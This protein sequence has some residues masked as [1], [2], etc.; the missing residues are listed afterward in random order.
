M[1]PRA[2]FSRSVL[3]SLHSP[4]YRVFKF[5]SPFPPHLPPHDFFSR[6]TGVPRTHL[7]FMVDETR[8]AVSL[9]LPLNLIQTSLQKAA[10][11]ADENSPTTRFADDAESLYSFDSVSTNGRLLDRL[12]LNIDTYDDNDVD[13]FARRRNLAILV[14]STGRLL[15]RLGLDDATIMASSPESST[16]GT[17]ATSVASPA[18]AAVSALLSAASVERYRPVRASSQISVE[19][20]R[21]L[22]RNPSQSRIALKQAPA[23]VV[24]QRSNT[25]V[26]SMAADFAV[27][28]SGSTASLQEPTAAV[29]GASMPHTPMRLGSSK[30]V[31]Q[32]SP[33]AED[34]ELLPRF[35]RSVSLGLATSV[36]S[37]DSGVSAKSEAL[38]E[39]AIR[40]ALLLRSQGKLREALYQLQ[41]LANA[42][43]NSPKAMLLYAMALRVGLGVKLNELQAVKWLSRCVLVLQAAELEHI[44][45]L[46]IGAMVAKMAALGPDELVA[47]V[48]RSRDFLESTDPVKIAAFYAS[49]PPGQVEKLVLTS[50]KDSTTQAAAFQQLG[51]CVLAGCGT[52]QK[53]EANGRFLLLAA[54]ALGS[55]DAMAKL[56][57]LWQLKTK[58]FKKDLYVAAAWL[59]LAETFGRKDIGNSWIYKDKYME[60]KK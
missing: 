9:R 4:R 54:A 18:S 10:S 32:L 56:G 3:S 28:G 45:E 43:T 16:S 26:S 1:P 11:Y 5:P 25:S 19:R 27:L 36:N 35:Q 34:S 47:L 6:C 60:P 24:S 38:V 37:G 51:E 46:E 7:N 30:S 21:L 20:M 53:N 58:T 33:I 14:L 8:P 39:S 49:L 23:Q 48:M 59:R 44:H 13:D 17:S 15:D 2:R 40:V 50:S 22:A 29:S 57:E 52:A 31:P 41:L 12:N 42:P 55:A